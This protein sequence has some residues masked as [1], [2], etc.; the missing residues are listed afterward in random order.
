M[1]RKYTQ[2][3]TRLSAETGESGRER[4]SP[5]QFRPGSESLFQPAGLDPECFLVGG[6]VCSRVCV[7]DDDEA[8]GAPPVA[9]A[10]SRIAMALPP[11]QLIGRP[12]A[13]SSVAISPD[14]T[15][16]AY[17]ANPQG[18]PTQIYLRPL[19]GLDAK[20]I[21]GTEGAAAP[22]FSPD[23]QWLG[24]FADGKLKKISIAGGTVVNLGGCDRPSGRQLG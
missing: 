11:E 2:D 24:F 23:G 1:P 21:P 16:L 19:E 5:W 10:V 3:L 18:G 17:V 14:G 9:F 12:T 6:N 15:R 20:P 22:F 7:V 4:P 13:G 8:G